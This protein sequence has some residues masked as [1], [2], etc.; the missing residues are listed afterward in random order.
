MKTIHKLWHAYSPLIHVAV[1]IFFAGVAWS[2]V[3]AYE[4]RIA[5]V[6]EISG[7]VSGDVREMKE[8]LR[9]IEKAL[10]RR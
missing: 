10:G 2:S 3:S 6:E 8:S 7:N 5:K 9:W 1:W 4:G